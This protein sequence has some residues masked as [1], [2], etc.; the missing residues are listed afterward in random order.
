[1]PPHP[2][3]VSRRTYWD[4][5]AETRW[6]AYLTAIERRVILKAQALAGHPQAAIDAGCGSG[7]W[8][9]MISELG[10]KVTCL[11]ISP[12]A[13]E[14]CRLNVPSA[15]GILTE[16]SDTSLPCETGSANL[17]LCIEAFP[18]IQADWFPTEARRVLAEDGIFVGVYMNRHSWRGLACQVKYRLKRDP[19]RNVFYTSAY[20]DWRRQL[21]QNGFELVHE[22]SCSWGPFS[23]ASNSMLV[24]AFT[25]FERLI[26]LSR[27]IA[28]SPWVVFIA[29]KRP[30]TPD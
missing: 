10:W 27:L 7:R 12:G 16:P 19:F 29:R 23:R 6:G 14:I 22:E 9:K 17:L 13:L 21:K 11:E 3:S 25:R 30:L 28:W 15:K 8:S 5:V 18:L 20:S 2:N 4:N 24:P 26:G 1:M